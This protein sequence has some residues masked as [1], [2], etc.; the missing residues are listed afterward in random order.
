MRSALSVLDFFCDR[1]TDLMA[2]EADLVTDWWIK[3]FFLVMVYF[4]ITK[5][6][7]GWGRFLKIFWEKPDF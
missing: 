1:F 6:L 2:E 7:P 5:N 4:S 3:F